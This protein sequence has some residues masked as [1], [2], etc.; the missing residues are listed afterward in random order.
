MAKLGHPL[1]EVNLTRGAEKAGIVQAISANA[2]CGLDEIMEARE[3][4]QKVIYQASPLVTPSTEAD[5][6][7]RSISIK[8][9]K[10]LRFF[11]K[12]WK[13]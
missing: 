9:A 13:S 5:N 12:K 3:E 7:V 2:S 11:S 8:I 4:G 6:H 10:R 1:G